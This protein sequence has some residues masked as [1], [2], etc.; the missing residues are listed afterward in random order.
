VLKALIRHDR[1]VRRQFTIAQ[2]PV[3]PKPQLAEPQIM[4]IALAAAKRGGDPRPSLIEHAGGTRFSAVLVGQG[5][6]VFAW[7][8]SYLIAV[9]GQFSYPGLGPPGS[10]A[11]LHATVITLVVDA[12]TGQVT[13]SGASNRYP[14]LARLGRVTTDLRR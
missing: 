5:D 1:F 4:R 3:Q 14:P 8:L 2:A 7:N 6:L 13:D 12:A 11:A 10:S 9:R